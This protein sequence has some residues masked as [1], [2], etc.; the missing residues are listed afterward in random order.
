MTLLRGAYKQQQSH[1]AALLTDSQRYLEP[2]R[3]W[4]GQHTPKVLLCHHWTLG[5]ST[6]LNKTGYI[7]KQNW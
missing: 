6:R 1:K 3:T 5:I 2:N 4:I 7:S